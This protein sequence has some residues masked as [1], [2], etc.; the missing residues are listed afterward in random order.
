LSIKAWLIS[1]FREFFLYHHHSLEF[2]AKIFALVIAACDNEKKDEYDKLKEI[3]N[4]IYPDDKKRQE[5]L[6][7]A[8]KE[9]VKKILNNQKFGF[10][11]FIKEIDFKIKTKKD[12]VKKIDLVHIKK[13]MRDDISENKK[14]L[15][16]RIYEFL[17]ALIR[18][19]V[20]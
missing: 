9:Y 14:I 4:E 6:V 5:V 10:D 1:S 12:F 15:Q 18:D 7:H 11:E 8:T 17:E 19:S 2:R 20:N 13:L 3:A 16:L